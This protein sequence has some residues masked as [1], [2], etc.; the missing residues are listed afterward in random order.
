MSRTSN[1]KRN[2]VSGILIQLIT[3]LLGF[4]NRTVFIHYLGANYLGLSGLF[5]N[6][7]SVLSLAELG[8]GDAITYALYKPLAE[9]DNQ[10]IS[11]LMSFYRVTYKVI[12]III[13]CMGICLLPFL[14]Y[15]I[16]FDIAIDIN[17]YYIYILFLFNS[18]ISYFFSHI[19]FL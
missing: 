2:I 11:I 8:I 4:I 14:K 9:N 18:V 3:S 5:T 19:E 16:N 12:G 1:T 10:K 13:F 17:Y 15:L 6:I 7:L